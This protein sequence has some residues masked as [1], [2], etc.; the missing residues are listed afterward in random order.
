MNNIKLLIPAAGQGTR[1]GLDYPKTLLVI[2][3]KTILSRIIEVFNKYDSCPTIIVSKKGKK[4]INDH[5]KNCS[6]RAELIVQDTAL[7]MGNSILCFKKSKFYNSSENLMVIWGVIPFIQSDT[8]DSVVKFHISN[9]NHFT[10]PTRFVKDPYTKVIRD[11]NNSVIDIQETRENI[12]STVVDGEREIGFFIFKNKIIL[13]MLNKNLLG[14]ISNITKEHG[15]LYL[16]KHLFKKGFKIQ[17]LP[18][19]TSDD[20]ISINTKIDLEKLKVK[21]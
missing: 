13:N 8:I 5:L 6:L 18:I 10:F 17:G 20:I 2:D 1:L 14:K 7:G 4:L 11:N 3:G 15:F 19:A 16:I 12:N 9:N 21:K